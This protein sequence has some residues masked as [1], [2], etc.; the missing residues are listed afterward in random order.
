MKYLAQTRNIL[1]WELKQRVFYITIG[2][3]IG[4]IATL[5]GF[6]IGYYG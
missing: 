3:W 4:F 2:I 6:I 1:K 5:I